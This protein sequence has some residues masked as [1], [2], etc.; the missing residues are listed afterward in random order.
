[1]QLV[2]A[3]QNGDSPA[4]YEPVLA[5]QTIGTAPVAEVNYSGSTAYTTY[6]VINASAAIVEHAVI[7]VA[8]AFSSSN[9]PAA[10]SVTVDPSFAPLSSVMTADLTAPLPRFV[11][12]GTPQPAY[13][14]NS[15]ACTYSLTLS[16]ASI[17]ASGGN[18]SFTVTTSQGCPI[19]PVS[20]SSFVSFT[21][22]G[23]VVSYT[24]AP[25]S[26]PYPRT[27]TITVGGQSF[28]LT[29]AAAALTFTPSQLKFTSGPGQR[30]AGIVGRPHA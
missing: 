24:V 2:Q 15:C 5:T 18:G 1:L 30:F 17:S 10:G 6:E 29:Q 11:D 19:Q 14:I 20:Q 4:G 16:S 13:A 26:L 22:A 12:F 25:N 23:S 8:V 7:P 28:T 9:P 3:D 27:A 21:V